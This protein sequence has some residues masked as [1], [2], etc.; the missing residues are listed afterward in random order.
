ARGVAVVELVSDLSHSDVGIVAVQVV[1]VVE[2]RLHRLGASDS[3]VHTQAQ[4]VQSGLCCMC[5][6]PS[7]S[8][9]WWKTHLA[10]QRAH[11]SPRAMASSVSMRLGTVSVIVVLRLKLDPEE[12]DVAAI[13]GLV[14]VDVHDDGDD[15][16]V[17]VQRD[18]DLGAHATHRS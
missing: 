11:F 17:D 15:D 5:L 12:T 1:D 13:D 10:P 9:T 3:S 8:G 6:Y 16:A 18:T 14:G 7:E 2:L 4:Y